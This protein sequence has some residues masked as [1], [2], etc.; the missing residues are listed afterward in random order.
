[1]LAQEAYAEFTEIDASLTFYY[2]THRSSRQGKTYDL[3]V[4]SADPAWYSDG[5]SL[6]V[7]SVYFNPSFD[8]VRPTTTSAWFYNMKSLTTINLRHLNTSEVTNMQSMFQDCQSL[9]TLDL[10]LL[11]T[12]KVENFDFMFSQCLEL[13]SLD[14]RGFDTRSA[15]SMDRMFYRCEGL[16]EVNLISFSTGNVRKM[17]QMFYGCKALKSIYVGSGWVTS[18]VANSDGMPAMPISTAVRAIPATSL[19]SLMTL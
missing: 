2:D 10:S 14:L 11:N 18:L 13:R 12:A 3:N 17:R 15:Y 1:M 9:T 4:G 6:K 5:T 16:T 19:R 7:R 8:A